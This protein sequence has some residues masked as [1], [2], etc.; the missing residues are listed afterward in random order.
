MHGNYR[1]IKAAAE[2]N[3]R[4]LSDAEKHRAFAERQA[5]ILNEVEFFVVYAD[6]GS[7][8]PIDG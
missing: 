5:G 4:R 6:D 8:V 3:G 7:R 2:L 1:E